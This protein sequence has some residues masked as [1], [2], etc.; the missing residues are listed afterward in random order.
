[1]ESEREEL[2]FIATHL[3]RTPRLAKLLRYLAQKYFDG[4]AGQLTEYRIATEVFD[5]EKTQF[6]ASDDAIARVQTHRLRK[7]LKEFYENEGKNRPVQVSIPLGTYVPSF[8]RQNAE[9]VSPV[10]T[11]GTVEESGPSEATGSP[12][13]NSELSPVSI[14]LPPRT[15]EHGGNAA[16][17]IKPKGWPWLYALI[18]IALAAFLLVV[19]NASRSRNTATA[20]SSKQNS[21]PIPPTSK[22]AQLPSVTLPFRIIAGYSGPPQR[23]SVGD[24]WQADQYSRGGWAAQQPAVFVARTSDPLIFRY[25]RDGGFSYD[26]PLQPGVYELHLY[27]FQL[28]QAAQSEDAENKSAFNVSINGVVTLPAFDIVSDAMGRNIADE[29]VLRDVSPASDGFLHLDFTSVIG[30]PSLSAIQLLQGIPHRQLPI[31]VTAQ[32]TSFTDRNGRLWHPD[33]YSLGGRHLAHNLPM[34]GSSDP[35]LLSEERYGHFTYAFPVDTRDR[36]T[37]VLHF[38]ELFFGTAEAGPS[39][40]GRRVFRVMCNGNTLLDDFNIY[41]EVG[42]YHML[43][44]TFYHLKPTAQGKLNLTFEP[45]SGDAT[46]SAIEILDETNP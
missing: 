18:A 37:I 25:G 1:M 44:K 42:D 14:E 27:F 35:D 17:P 24:L 38:V 8:H 2:E 9:N 12:L 6:I 33:D 22:A 7:T 46:V 16:L 41:K 34:N 39:E 23:D 43:T 11:A 10:E 40:T 4:E 5:R 32:L 28:S 45:I 31:R 36:Y 13:Q 21:T 15:E 3:E 20:S 26:I 29:R 19:Y 30:T